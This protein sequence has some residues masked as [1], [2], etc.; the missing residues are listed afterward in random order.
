MLIGILA[1][2]PIVIETIYW[3]KVD[4]T[5]PLRLSRNRP[6]LAIPSLNAVSLFTVVGSTLTW[7]AQLSAMGRD[8]TFAPTWYCTTRFLPLGIIATFGGSVFLVTTLYL[9][10]TVLFQV[11][12]L[13]Q[14]RSFY[15]SSGGFAV[16]VGIWVSV[17]SVG[18][19]CV[20]YSIYSINQIVS[21]L[22]VQHPELTSPE[23]W[24]LGQ[25]MALIVGLAPVWEFANHYY[26][27][28]KESIEQIPVVKWLA[29]KVVEAWVRVRPDLRCTVLM[30]ICLT[31]KLGPATASRRL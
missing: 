29:Q 22:Y 20:E 13:G 9:C 12:Y 27:L 1:H 2:I 11:L 10:F 16:I 26:E 30:F 17:S 3:R 31:S 28:Y 4:R 18:I 24:R 5:T 7:G 25:V 23:S 14:S 6:T 21:A 15:H 19:I 8:R